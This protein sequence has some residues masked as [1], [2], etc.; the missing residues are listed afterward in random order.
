MA[1]PTNFGEQ[2]RPLSLPGHWVSRVSG[3]GDVWLVTM[4]VS[5]QSWT[6]AVDTRLLDD[7]DPERTDF[8]TLAKW[9]WR[10][11]GGKEGGG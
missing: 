5:G 7:G 9:I 3:L 4:A 8:P 11:A 2:S 1:A 10:V 6:Q